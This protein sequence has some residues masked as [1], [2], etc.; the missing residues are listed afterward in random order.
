[1]ITHNVVNLKGENSP[2]QDNASYRHNQ[3]YINRGALPNQT[4]NAVI[5]MKES[6]NLIQLHNTVYGYAKVMNGSLIYQ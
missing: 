4:Y 1:M 3:L 6:S 5:L 2:L